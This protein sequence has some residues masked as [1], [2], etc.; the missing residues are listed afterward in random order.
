MALK[1]HFLSLD[2]LKIRLWL[3]REIDVSSGRQSLG[4]HFLPLDHPK[5][6]LVEF[7]KAVFQ[8]V[9]YNFLF[10]FRLLARPKCDLSEVE[11][12]MFQGVA[13]HSQLILGIWTS[14]NCDEPIGYHSSQNPVPCKS[15]RKFYEKRKYLSRHFLILSLFWRLVRLYL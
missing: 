9:A 15:S 5:F 11:K 14:L 7:E 3:C 6:D 13:W 1:S 10:I 2:K 4:T 8:G 12:A